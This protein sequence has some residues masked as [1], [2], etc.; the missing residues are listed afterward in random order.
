M[1]VRN[2]LAKVVVGGF[3]AASIALIGCG[4]GGA[5][6][7]PVSGSLYSDVKFNGA[8]YNSSNAV[9]AKQSSEKCAQSYLGL[10]AMGDASVE[11]ARADAGISKVAYIDYHRTTISSSLMDTLCVQVAGE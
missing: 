11:T 10:V 7:P 4:G 3:C 5:G 9:A 6:T 1:E 8:P 2:I